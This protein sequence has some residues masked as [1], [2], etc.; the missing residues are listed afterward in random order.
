MS[1]SNDLCD[2]VFSC[3]FCQVWVEKD[4]ELTV[5]KP[6]HSSDS[7]ALKF[8]HLNIML[9]EYNVTFVL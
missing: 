2:I 7:A 1:L 8:L 4:D 9:S 5:I 3:F 6:H